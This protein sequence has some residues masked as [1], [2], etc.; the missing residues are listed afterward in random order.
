MN[1]SDRLRDWAELMGRTETP[2][3]PETWGRGPGPGSRDGQWACLEGRVNV[4]IDGP[5][6]GR[7]S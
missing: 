6:T 4:V 1:D 7:Q 5:L 2:G 3:R